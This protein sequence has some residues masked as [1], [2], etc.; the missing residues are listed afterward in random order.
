MAG[1]GISQRSHAPSELNDRGV[2]VPPVSPE[3]IKI[4]LF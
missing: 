3:V 4:L 2:A 1:K